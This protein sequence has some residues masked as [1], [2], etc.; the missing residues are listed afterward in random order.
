VPLVADLPPSPPEA[1]LGDHTLVELRHVRHAYAAMGDVDLVHDHTVAGPLYRY[2]PP[3]LPVVTTN[4]GA[5]VYGLGDL[6]QALGGDV[7]IV[8]ISHHQASTAE[9]VPIARVIHHGLDLDTTPVGT[10]DGGYACFLGRVSPDK[11]IREAILIARRAGVPL[12]VAAK[13]RQK[14]EREYYAAVVAPLLGGDVQYIGELAEAE[15]YHLLGGAFALLN[16]I[17]W[18]EPFGLVMIEA[19]AAG[20]PVVGTP[21][22]AAPEI[23]DDGVTGYLRPG[24]E[25]LTD[26]LLQAG[27]LDRAACRSAVVDR[28]STGRMVADHVE[29]Y[30][31]LVDAIPKRRSRRVLASVHDTRDAG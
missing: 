26:A 8:A 5:F 3:H 22:G 4:H 2:R 18:P 7:R 1:E 15:K 29:L 9:G 25:E 17:Q 12:F 24:L 13:M 6:Y 27:E 20:T 30:S 21:S 10:G 14:A 16:P 31:E 23:V 19:L 11:G 28:F